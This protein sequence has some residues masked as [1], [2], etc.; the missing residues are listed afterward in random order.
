MKI[1]A[2]IKVP[3]GNNNKPRRSWAM[4]M[5]VSLAKV[6]DDDGTNTW[7]NY[8]NKNHIPSQSVIDQFPFPY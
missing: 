3:M 7:Q 6:E 8:S 5:A 2:K 4:A 1:R